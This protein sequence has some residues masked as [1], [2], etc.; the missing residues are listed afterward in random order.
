MKDTTLHPDDF[1]KA[2]EAAFARFQVV[3]EEAY[4]SQATC[5]KGNSHSH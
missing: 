2:F 1:A 5:V 4:V 3:V